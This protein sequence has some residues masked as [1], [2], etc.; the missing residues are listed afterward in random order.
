MVEARLCACDWLSNG[1][2]IRRSSA[3]FDARQ[4]RIKCAHWPWYVAST[5]TL[6][7]E[8]RLLGRNDCTRRAIMLAPCSRSAQGAGPWPAA[9]RSI[10]A[11]ALSATESGRTPAA[12][13]SAGG[14]VCRYRD[15]GGGGGG[16]SVDRARPG[17]L[18][19]APKRNESSTKRRP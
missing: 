9:P 6:L 11:Q 10:A 7:P 18:S 13:V 1:D 15:D 8:T 16:L 19:P 12:G 17:R 3:R 14:E 5:P 2:E 4:R